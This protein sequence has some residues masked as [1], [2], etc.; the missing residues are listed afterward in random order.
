MTC[1]AVVRHENNIYMAG[2]RGASTEDSILELKAPKVFKIGPYLFGYAGTMDGER[3]RHNF[4]PPTPKQNV[5]L[6]K[7]MYTDFLVALR[8]FYENWWV[9]ISKDSDFGMIICIKGRIFEHNAVDMSLTE[10]QQ[11]FLCMGSGSA[12]AYGSLY[13]TQK[14]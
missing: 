2:D 9:D 5:N 7:F 1:I 12:Y 8:N 10:Y 11:P 13:S 6:D 4:K 3:I 14:Q